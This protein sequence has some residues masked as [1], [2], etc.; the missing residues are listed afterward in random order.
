MFMKLEG[1]E[2]DVVLAKLDET[3]Y[4]TKEHI[5]DLKTIIIVDQKE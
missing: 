4:F 1:N 3:I 2:L 5:D